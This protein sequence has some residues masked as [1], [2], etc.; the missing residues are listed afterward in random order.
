MVLGL[1]YK[2]LSRGVG[3]RSKIKSI[4][5]LA[6]Q[7]IQAQKKRQNYFGRRNNWN[8]IQKWILLVWTE[9]LGCTK[10]GGGVLGKFHHRRHGKIQKGS[11]PNKSPKTKKVFILKETKSKKR[12][13][14]ENKTTKKKNWSVT[15]PTPLGK[16]SSPRFQLILKQ[17]WVLCPKKFLALPSCF[18]LGVITPLNSEKLNGFPSGPPLRLF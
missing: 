3:L 12:I 9:C 13:F 14:A 16:I 1:G 15:A 18:I 4:M 11:K 6:S 17:V 7:I 8:K 5:V 2:G 10:V